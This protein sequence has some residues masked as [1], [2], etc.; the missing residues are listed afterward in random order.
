MA[1]LKEEDIRPDALMEKQKVFAAVDVGRL[2]SRYDEFVHA[3]CPAC[4]VDDSEHK[5]EKNG[6]KYVECRNCETFYINPRPTK[7]ILAWFYQESP[8]YAYW[9]DVIF[10]SSESVRREKIFAPR[11]DRLLELCEKY[12]IK[13]H[14]LLEVG[15]GFGTFCSELKSRDVFKKV[16]AVEP[17]PDLAET[18]RTKGIDVIEK[19]VED[20]VLNKDEIPKYKGKNLP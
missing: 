18:C 8:N 9:N 19:P 2:L 1:N 4:G 11:V 7:E 16:V 13:T 6:M 3:N 20:V 17:T 12:E 5:F 10:P 14:S 15:A